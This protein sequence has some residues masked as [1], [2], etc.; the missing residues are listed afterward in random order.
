MRSHH[1][2]AQ[3]QAQNLQLTQQCIDD[4]FDLVLKEYEFCDVLYKPTHVWNTDECG[5][6]CEKNKEK[7]IVQRG[8][9]NPHS[10][11]GLF[12]LLLLL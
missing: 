2:L 7:L 10:L 1:D 4:F 6:Q 3:R 9:K 11:Q 8:M 5:F 12:D